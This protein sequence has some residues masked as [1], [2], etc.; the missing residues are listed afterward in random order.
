M[1]QFICDITIQIY[2]HGIDNI[3]DITIQIDH[4][5]VNV[6]DINTD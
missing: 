5:I 6:W 3:W 4:D 1:A 2:H